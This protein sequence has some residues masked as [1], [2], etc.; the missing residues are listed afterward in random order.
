MSRAVQGHQGESGDF[1]RRLRRLRQFVIAGIAL[2]MTRCGGNPN[3]EGNVFLDTTRGFS[4][5]IPNGWS[6]SKSKSSNDVVL[7]GPA[8]N[9]LQPAIRFAGIQAS[10]DVSGDVRH[11]VDMARAR[12]PNEVRIIGETTFAT[13]SG[14]QGILLL[15]EN[16]SLGRNWVERSYTL[17]QGTRILIVTCVCPADVSAGFDKLCDD[18]LRTLAMRGK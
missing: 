15:M 7:L 12:L 4:I 8:H 17:G 9:G 6:E 1:R 18:A 10:A 14:M 16:K 11:A 13:E 2:A 5:T 3:P